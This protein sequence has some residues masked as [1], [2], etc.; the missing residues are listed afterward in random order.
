MVEVKFLGTAGA[1]FA[2][3]KQLRYSAGVFLR[4]ENTSL[5]IDPGPGTLLR[6]AKAKPK[7]DIDSIDGLIL[8]HSHLDH[9]TDAN[10]ILDSIS[11]G[12]LRKKGFLLTTKEALYSENH[13]VLPYILNNLCEYRTFEHGVKMQ[14]RDLDITP[15]LHIHPV[16]TYGIKIKLN[17]IVVSFVAD[18]NYFPEIIRYYEGS[19]FLILN[20]V[21][22]QKKEN[23][24]HLSVED[25]ESI[26]EGIKP[27]KAIITHFGLT[28]LRN[29]P[30]EIAQKMSKKI[31]IDVIAAEDGMNF[32]FA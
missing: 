17:D 28:M 20:V 18:T 27:R 12:G 21:R 15:Y 3:A 26:I 25:A 4:T 13:V 11:Q 9:S 22:F 16:E 23:V 2:V 5:I 30:F 24:M 1:R 19:D 32:N 7:I 10:V 14:V 8:T 31:G 29:R 6:L